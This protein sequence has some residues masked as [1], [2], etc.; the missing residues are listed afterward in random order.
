MKKILSLFV[1]CLL[2]NSVFAA[3][4]SDTT[5]TVY[6]P[7]IGN[8]NTQIFNW[9]IGRTETSA[10]GIP[11]ALYKIQL[12]ALTNKLSFFV[13][14]DHYFANYIDPIAYGQNAPQGGL[15]YKF[16]SQTNS[17]YAV[18][19]TFNKDVIP[20]SYSDSVGVIIDQV[21]LQD[22]LWK[23]LDN[24]LVFGDVENG[25]SF[26]VTNGNDL[27]KVNGMGS[28]LTVAGG[29]ELNTNSTI[30][31][32][33]VFRQNNGTTYFIDK[34]IQ[35]VLKSVYKVLSETPAFSSF[36]NL[37]NG[38]PDTCVYKIFYPQGIDFVINNFHSY[39]YTVYVPTNAA[40]QAAIDQ[41]IIKNWSTLSAM[42][43]GP[44][45]ALEINKLIRFLK[46]HF[47]DEAVFF[48]QDTNG[49]FQTATMKN[50]L[51]ASHFQSGKNRFYKIGVTG[52]ETSMTLT[53]E[54]NQTAHV[55][56]ADGLY[57][58]IA[59]D[60]LFSKV[61]SYYKNVDGSGPSAGATF[62]SSSISTSSSAVIHQIDQVLTFQ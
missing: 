48:G 40:I 25:K 55:V 2:I 15:Q 37:L 36:F 5:T 18:V 29:Y 60:Y 28:A 61:P 50:D 56:T 12:N 16:N 57:N 20:L 51:A 13:P 14:T 33:A 47:Q 39:R 32:T 53:T 9:A 23:M 22:R 35:P 58:I 3:S 30:K 54:T 10:E 38:I 52:N 62:I 59:K 44:L 1:V 41:G 43:N 49:I 34:P 42:S 31:T 21:F 17:V 8:N 26:Y 45:K 24:H 46:Y 7:L 27:I 11:Y 4:S 19:R 6:Y